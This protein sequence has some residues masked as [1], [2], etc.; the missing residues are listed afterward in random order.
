[1]S[2]YINI[3][4]VIVTIITMVIRRCNTNSMIFW[5]VH[6]L[7]TDTIDIYISSGDVSE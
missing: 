5:Y 4:I 3:V 2:T 7:H 1:M 6:I